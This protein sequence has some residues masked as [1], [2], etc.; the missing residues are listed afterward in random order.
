MIVL[1]C[2]WW[3][4]LWNVDTNKGVFAVLSTVEL[5]GELCFLIPFCIVGILVFIKERKRKQ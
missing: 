1:L 3:V 4:L 5:A 2:Y